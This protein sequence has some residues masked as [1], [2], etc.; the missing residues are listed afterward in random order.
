MSGDR[1]YDGDLL[2]ALRRGDQA[3]RLLAGLLAPLRAPEAAPLPTA[4]LATLCRD[5][6]PA[7]V[8]AALPVVELGRGGSATPGPATA[9][10]PRR[11]ALR[12]AIGAACAAA[13]L[14]LVAVLASMPSGDD[15]VVTPIDESPASSQAPRVD[16]GHE[17]RGHLGDHTTPQR[18]AR[19]HGAARGTAQTVQP[20]ATVS[21]TTSGRS[22]PVPQSQGSTDRGG[23]RTAGVRSARPT[24]RDGAVDATTI[25]TAAEEASPTPPA[26]DDSA[27]GG[28][29]D[30]GG[31]SD[32][33]SD[34]DDPQPCRRTAETPRC[35]TAESDVG[36][37]AAPAP[38]GP[39]E[40]RPSACRA[41]RPGARTRPPG[42][43]PRRHRPGW[44]GLRRSCRRPP[45]GAA[46][47]R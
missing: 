28:S 2:T 30:G 8:G 17:G 36:L 39:R 5:E 32:G 20:G 14:G 3:D 34:G 9:S 37:L 31:S 21:T 23:D 38:S 18:T 41:A 33:G 15:V 29:D 44:P 19:P 42:G 4:A 26:G 16:D 11:S 43:P 1:S 27:D 12:R 45:G 22:G 7:P 10:R 40:R 24:G 13:V 6:P 47:H 35:R 46:R 25:G